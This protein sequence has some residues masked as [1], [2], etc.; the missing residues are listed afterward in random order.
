MKKLILVI[1]ISAFVN[2]MGSV[3]Q[4]KPTTQTTPKKAELNGEDLIAKSDCLTC[5]QMHVKVIGPAYDMV[6]T[7]YKPTEE[8][9]K[10][11]SEKIIN[12]GTGVWGAFPM[13]PHPTLK[14]E[15]VR[16]MVKFILSVKPEEE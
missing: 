14:E 16:A 9:I 4:T 1:C 5:H 15:E 6:A 11:L 7:K 10:L 3:A 12:G 8:N 13:T 2:V